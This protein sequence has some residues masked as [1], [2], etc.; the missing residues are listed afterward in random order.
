MIDCKGKILVLLYKTVLTYIYT[1][2]SPSMSDF[3]SLEDPD[4]YAKRSRSLMQH[5]YPLEIT[6]LQFSQSDSL[7]VRWHW[8]EEIELEYIVSGISR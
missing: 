1:E 8:H 6:R 4:Y 5:D 3:H 2:R 7:L